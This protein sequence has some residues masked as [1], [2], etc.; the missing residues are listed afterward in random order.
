MSEAHQDIHRNLVSVLLTYPDR[1]IQVLDKN[2]DV[3][4]EEFVKLLE[5][6]STEMVN[7]GNQAAATFLE[8]LAGQIRREFL[9]VVIQVGKET[10]RASEIISRLTRYQLLPQFL[11]EVVIDQAIAS[12]PCTPDERK[13]A[14]RGFFQQNGI[15]SDE[16]CQAW[17]QRNGFTFSQLQALAV[18]PLKIH[19]FQQARWGQH[20]E[21]YFLQ[22]KEDLDQVTYSLIRVKSAGLAQELYFR[23]D[24]GEADFATV[25]RQ[26]SQGPEAQTGGLVGPMSLKMPH[27]LIAQK[28][29]TAQPQQI[30]PPIKI[31]DWFIIVRLEQFVP[32]QLNNGMKQQLM[33]ELFQNWLANQLNQQSIQL[34]TSAVVQPSAE[35]PQLTP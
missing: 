17:C 20:L 27:P 26:Y 28:L 15:K 6:M 25:A 31:E 12:V 7:R 14:L 13:Q 2:Q 34:M 30:F 1:A 19:K 5:A 4:D 18:R 23:I 8:Q 16:D 24:E 9:N 33:N 32:A 29:K 11:S 21:S 22:R 3:I 10:I 35:L